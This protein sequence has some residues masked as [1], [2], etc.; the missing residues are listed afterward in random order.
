MITRT[1]S[2]LRCL[3]LVA[4]GFAALAAT[5]LAQTV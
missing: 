3:A 5:L 2:I 4:A 1:A